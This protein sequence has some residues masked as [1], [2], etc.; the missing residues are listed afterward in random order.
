MPLSIDPDQ[1]VRALGSC[2]SRLGQLIERVGPFSLTLTDSWSPFQALVHSVIFQQISR[3]AGRSIQARLWDLF[4]GAPEPGDVIRAGDDLLRSAGLSRNKVATIRGLAQ[5]SLAGTLPDSAQLIKMDDAAI[6]DSL[7]AHRGIGVW[8]AQ[9]LLIFHLG[10]P[11]VL[12]VTDLGVR[13]GFRIAY[14]LD[15]LPEAKALA[16]YGQRWQPWRTVASWYL[17][18]AND[19]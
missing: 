3:S 5:S 13:R 1:A 16:I 15:E 19:L 14:A 2:D 18:R 11:D 6:M 12:P 9:M 8:T 4:G 7:T 17:W 10:R